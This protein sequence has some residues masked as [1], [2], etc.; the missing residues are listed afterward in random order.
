VTLKFIEALLPTTAVASIA[1]T[2]TPGMENRSPMV[3]WNFTSIW[4]LCRA[5]NYVGGDDV[6]T[7]QSWS[8][9]AVVDDI[10]A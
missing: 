10:A 2:A 1:K 5:W 4:L 8:N 7:R 3:T 6:T 9:I